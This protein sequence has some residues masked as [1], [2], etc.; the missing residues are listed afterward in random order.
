MQVLHR[1]DGSVAITGQLHD[2]VVHANLQLRL[3]HT[4]SFLSSFEAD[5]SNGGIEMSTPTLLA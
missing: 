4:L 3:L 5:G 1:S 2:S